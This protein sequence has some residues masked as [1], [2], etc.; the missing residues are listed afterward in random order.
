MYEPFLIFP[1]GSRSYVAKDGSVT[2]K[3]VSPRFV[4]AYFRPDDVVLPISLVGGSDIG[5]SWRLKPANIGLCVG[6]P[7]KV[8]EEM[9]ANFDTEGVGIM[10]KV[11]ALPNIKTVNFDE[12]I[13]AGKKLESHAA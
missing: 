5:N 8:S 1:E 9:I 4:Q 2:M 7:I 6:E 13:Q 12:D 3:Y 11:A 10:R